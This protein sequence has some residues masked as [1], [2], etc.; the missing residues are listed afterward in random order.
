MRTPDTTLSATLKR[1]AVALAR[2]TVVVA[3]RELLNEPVECLAH[4]W[5]L[6]VGGAQFS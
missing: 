2:E 6:G 4:L 3:T 5:V 1:H